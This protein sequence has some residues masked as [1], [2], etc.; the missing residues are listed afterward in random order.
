MILFEIVHDCRGGYFNFPSTLAP[1]FSAFVDFWSFIA[2]GENQLLVS[3]SKSLIQRRTSGEPKHLWTLDLSSMSALLSNRC[4]SINQRHLSLICCQ[5]V[6]WQ[7]LTNG[8]QLFCSEMSNTVQGIVA[9]SLLW[10]FKLTFDALRDFAPLQIFKNLPRTIST[11]ALVQ[12]SSF[13]Q[14]LKSQLLGSDHLYF[15][16][17]AF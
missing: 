13:R 7:A 8:L 15:H 3:T 1:H 11:R 6:V 12:N 4:Q 16:E 14:S 9:A 10:P 17:F 2:G 5:F